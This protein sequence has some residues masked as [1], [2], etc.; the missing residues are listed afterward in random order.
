MYDLTVRPIQS[1]IYS[2]AITFFDDQDR[3][4]WY[5]LEARAEEP[6]PEAEK[7]LIAQCRQAVELKITVYNP[8]DEETTFTVTIHGEGM[9]GDSMFYLGAKEEGVY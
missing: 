9:I 3:F 7:V 2:G 1:G 4:Y 5:T 6:E 8:Y